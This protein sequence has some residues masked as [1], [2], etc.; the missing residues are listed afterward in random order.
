MN[1]LT[2]SSKKKTIVLQ[3]LELWSYIHESVESITA[4]A[5][6]YFIVF[7]RA[8]HPGKVQDW[9]NYSIK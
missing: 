8:F 9:V 1:D 2:N 6:T 4:N 3:C 5:A 7:L